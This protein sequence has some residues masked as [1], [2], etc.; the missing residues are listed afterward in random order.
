[1]GRS[2]CHTATESRGIIAGRA[3]EG[4]PPE[5]GEDLNLRPLGLELQENKVLLFYATQ[6]VL[7]VTAA[8]KSQMVCL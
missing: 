6:S 1:M 2:R 7:L 5:V 3:T 8:M 4:P